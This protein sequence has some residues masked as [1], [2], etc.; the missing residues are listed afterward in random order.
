MQP[1]PRTSTWSS[2]P[3]SLT[4]FSRFSLTPFEFEDMQP[5]AMQHRMVY[6]L[7]P[8]RSFSA[9]CIRSSMSMADPSFH[10]LQGRLGGLAGCDGAVVD[11]CGGNAAGADA[12]GGQQRQLVV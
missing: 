2:S 3:A 12:P 4:A 5:A 8:A 6:F 7:R 1:T 9:I 11:Y 10:L